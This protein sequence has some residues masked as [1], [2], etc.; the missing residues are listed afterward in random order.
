[1]E[2]IEDNC[3]IHNIPINIKE[4]ADG[5][6]KY[7]IIHKLGKKWSMIQKYVLENLMPIDDSKITDM[8]IN[9]DYMSFK[10]HH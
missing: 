2:T 5:S 6:K 8:K 4:F 10:V 9:C 3:V 1:M 7:V